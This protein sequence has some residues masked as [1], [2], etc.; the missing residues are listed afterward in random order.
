MGAPSFSGK[1][2]GGQD[3]ARWAS[4]HNREYVVRFWPIQLPM[5]GDRYQNS[6]P[7]SQSGRGGGVMQCYKL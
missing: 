6:H 5:A 1:G 3:R 7:L 4:F 2:G